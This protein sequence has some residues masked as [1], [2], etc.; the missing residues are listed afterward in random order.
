MQLLRDR[1]DIFALTKAL[2]IFILI[3]VAV[4]LVG[5]T[6]GAP[7]PHETT[8]SYFLSRAVWWGGVA[9]FFVYVL[10]G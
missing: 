10:D 1:L 3:L 6:I 8:L 9:A 7:P 4:P 5:M 2:G